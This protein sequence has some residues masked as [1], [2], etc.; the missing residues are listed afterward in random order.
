MAAVLPAILVTRPVPRARPSRLRMPAQGI[1]SAGLWSLPQ[2][3]PAQSRGR[4]GESVAAR[5]APTPRRIASPG[6]PLVLAA[7]LVSVAAVVAPERPQD[8][9]A[10]C[11][12]HSGVL[13]CR[14][15]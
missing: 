1:G 13:A 15:W 10:I 4:G 2:F 3:C 7:I 8:Q 5:R 14:V 9:E 11:Q 6:V 12:R